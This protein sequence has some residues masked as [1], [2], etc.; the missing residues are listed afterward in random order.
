[1]PGH[2][3]YDIADLPDELQDYLTQ[4]ESEQ[5][6]KLP[7]QIALPKDDIETQKQEDYIKQLK[8]LTQDELSKQRR[9]SEVEQL[10]REMRKELGDIKDAIRKMGVLL[11]GDKPSE[12]VLREHKM[13]RDAY[14]KYKMIENLI[15][16]KGTNG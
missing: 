5:V 4:Y 6:K 9:L 13:L 14:N 8:Q 12:K 7:R 11:D 10:R 3:A 16:G 1:M 15:L 2:N